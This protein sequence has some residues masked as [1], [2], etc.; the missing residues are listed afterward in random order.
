M[1][2]EDSTTKNQFISIKEAWKKGSI[3]QKEVRVK[4]AGKKQ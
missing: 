1:Q 3:R 2:E 4:V